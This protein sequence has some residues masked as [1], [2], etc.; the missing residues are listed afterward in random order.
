[1]G[2]AAA[3]AA[4]VGVAI[5]GQESPDAAYLDILESRSLREALLLTRFSFKVRTWLLGSQQS[6]EQTLFEYL[7]K[8]NIDR[9]VKALKER[10]TVTRDI[11]TKLITI[12]VETES[13]QLS[14]Q[15]AQSLIHQ[16]DNFVV[17]KS[18]TRGGV[19]AAFSENRLSE[20]RQEMVQAEDSFRRFLDGNRNYL[21][22]SDPAVRLKGIRLDGELK[23]R[24]QIVTTLAIAREQ[25]LLEEKNDMPILNVLDAGNLP[26]EKS[27]PSRS[28]AVGIAV[29][30]GFILSLLI[31][32]RTRIFKLL[33]SD[34]TDAV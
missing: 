30:C 29:T 24:T 7:D 27:G 23:L 11:K 8:K 10:I 15:L 34:S 25:A 3:A 19:K 32:N 9:A 26:I 16:L 21:Q 33:I 6:R 20:A 17:A 2:T 5:P 14:Q 22:S 12:V 13:P 4:A 18:Q 28:L 31:R 1:M